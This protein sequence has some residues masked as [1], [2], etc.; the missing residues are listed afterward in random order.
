MYILSLTCNIWRCYNDL[1]T[2]KARK[3]H[4]RRSLLDENTVSLVQVFD[5][6]NNL[7]IVKSRGVK[8][9]VGDIE[10]YRL[11]ASVSVNLLGKVTFESEYRSDDKKL[12]PFAILNSDQKTIL[13]KR[14]I[15][16]RFSKLKKLS[17]G[18]EAII[19]FPLTRD[20]MMKLDYM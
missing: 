3:K 12:I 6:L 13:N 20:I 8:T 17:S 11:C 9:V 5:L 1:R 15:K 19:C 7:C 16:F 2:F 10:K 18:E 4:K 14:K